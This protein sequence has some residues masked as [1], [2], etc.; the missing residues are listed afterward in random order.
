M[1]ILPLY[2][3]DHTHTNHPDLRKEYRHPAADHPQMVPTPGVLDP[4]DP[5]AYLTSVWWLTSFLFP[6]HTLYFT[7][8]S[9]TGHKLLVMRRTSLL[10]TKGYILSTRQNASKCAKKQIWHGEF[11]FFSVEVMVTG[12]VETYAFTCGWGDAIPWAKSALYFHVFL[13]LAFTSVSYKACVVFGPLFYVTQTSKIS[14][15]LFMFFPS[16]PHPPRTLQKKKKI[17]LYQ[18]ALLPRLPWWSI[19]DRAIFRGFRFRLRPLDYKSCQHYLVEFCFFC[20]TPLPRLCCWIRVFELE[21]RRLSPPSTVVV[22][23]R[24]PPLSPY[25]PLHM[26]HVVEPTYMSASPSKVSVAYPPTESTH[27]LA[28]LCVWGSA[29]SNVGLTFSSRH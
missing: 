20:F 23:I 17:T 5:C 7:Q 21:G 15:H 12:G 18:R 25:E 16:Q 11:L 1:T 14:F 19:F 28:H 13:V 26:K 9:H 27:Y 8:V 10:T 2:V 29:A 22:I 4:A 3:Q 24:W 6:L